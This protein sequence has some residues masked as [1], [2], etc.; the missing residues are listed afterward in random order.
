MCATLKLPQFSRLMELWESPQ[1][2][3]LD[4]L[5]ELWGRAEPDVDLI[6]QVEQVTTSALEGP[7]WRFAGISEHGG[8]GCG[9]NHNL[10]NLACCPDFK[11]RHHAVEM[12][13]DFN[14]YLWH[15]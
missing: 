11:V 13:L 2:G 10:G 14:E 8:H 1:W 3:A 9:R 7:T 5:V 4:E 6:K 15:S 12:A